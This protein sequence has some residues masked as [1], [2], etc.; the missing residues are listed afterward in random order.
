MNR[1]LTY[2]LSLLAL[3]A[4]TT[5]GPADMG[6]DSYASVKAVD[7][8]EI[9]DTG[10]SDEGCTLD[11]RASSYTAQTG[12]T[13][14]IEWETANYAGSEVQIRLFS[15][16]GETYYLTEY[17][18]NDG[19]HDVALPASLDPSLDYDFY[20]ESS[21]NGVGTEHCWDYALLLL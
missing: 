3:V 12:T 4:C 15:G 13:L 5:E 8:D 19:S 10:T 20:I 1:N 21:E 7:G 9:S 2:S 18:A 14:S 17:T 6:G 16:W 11:F